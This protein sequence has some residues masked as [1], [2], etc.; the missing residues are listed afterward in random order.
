MAIGNIGNIGNSLPVGSTTGLYGYQ[1]TS[2]PINGG[3]A[4]FYNITVQNNANIGNTLTVSNTI[5]TANLYTGNIYTDGYFYANGAQFIGGGSGG[6]SFGL[7]YVIPDG[8]IIPSLALAPDSSIKF[9]DT[10]F[11]VPNDGYY[12]LGINLITTTSA[13]V[14]ITAGLFADNV[15]VSNT[16]VNLGAAD[17]AAIGYGNL[18]SASGALVVLL[19]AGVTYTVGVWTNSFANVTVSSRQQDGYSSYSLGYLGADG[20]YSDL[21]VSRYLQGNIASNII[22][23]FNGEQILGNTARPWGTAFV[24]NV[25]IGQNSITSNGPN[26]QINE[27]TIVT[28]APNGDIFSTGNLF[29]VG[30]VTGTYLFGD[31]TFISNIGG[32]TNYGNANVAAFMITTTSNIG[33]VGFAPNAI[34]SNSYFYGNGEPF[35][36]GG[37]NGNAI[38]NGTSNVSILEPDGSIEFQVNGVDM[39]HIRSN[40]VAIGANAGLT[41]QL[42]DA[43]AIGNGAGLNTQGANTVAIGSG[44]GQSNQGDNAIAIGAFAGNTNQSANSIIINA[45]GLPLDTANTGFYVDPIRNDDLN[46]ANTVF[47]NQTTK[48]LTF[49]PASAASYGNANVELLLASGNID[50]NI[51]LSANGFFVGDGR[52]L[53]NIDA[54]NLIG[55]YGNANVAGFLPIYTGEM[56]SLEGD[57][58]TQANIVGNNIRTLGNI[59]TDNISGANNVIAYNFIGNTVRITGDADVGGNLNVIGNVNYSNI[60]E[61]VVGDSLVQIAAN[62]TTNLLDIGFFGQYN[63]GANIYTGFVRDYTDGN[64]KLFDNL[65]TQP[66]ANDKVDFANSVSGNLNIGILTATGNLTTTGNVVATGNV[67]GNYILGDGSQLINLPDSSIPADGETI[68]IGMGFAEPPQ[69][70]VFLGTNYAATDL[71]T[72]LSALSL[73]QDGDIITVTGTITITATLAINKR[74]FI[75][76][77]GTITTAGTSADP[78]TMLNITANNVV[79]GDNLTITHAKTTNTSVET[80]ITVNALNFVSGAE[81]NFVEFGY[82][83]R[84]SFNISGVVSQYVGGLANNHRHFTIFRVSAPSQISDIIYDF[85]TET[86]PRSSFIYVSTGGAGD[87]FT[88]SLVVKNT[89]QVDPLKIQRQ[90]YLQDT[91][92]NVNSSGIAFYNNQFNDLNGGIGFISASQAPL[93]AFAK[94]GILENTQGAAGAGIF[95]G[96]CYFD[97]SNGPGRNLGNTQ[98][99]AYNNVTAGGALRTDYTG[100]YETNIVAARN[101]I[102]NT[103]QQLVSIDDGYNDA[104]QQ[105]YDIRYSNANVANYLGSNANVSITTT[106]NVRVGNIFTDGYYYANGLP[107]AGGGNGG[108]NSISFGNTSVVIPSTGGNI[109]FT[110]A[111]VPY[112]NLTST[113]LALGNNAGQGAN[114]GNFTVALGHTAGFEFQAAYSVAVGALAGYSTQQSFSVAVGDSAGQDRQGVAAVAIGSRAGRILQ[115]DDATAVGHQAAQQRQGDSAVAIGSRAGQAN[116]GANSIAI[117]SLAGAGSL[118]ANTSG[119]GN[120][121][122]II[123]ATGSSLNQPLANTFTVAPI[124][125]N[126]ANITNGLYYNSITGEITVGQIGLV[127][128]GTTSIVIPTPNAQI[129]FNVS[130]VSNALSLSVNTTSNLATAQLTGSYISRSNVSTATSEYV[131]QSDGGSFI[132]LG[133]AGSAYNNV[134][135][136]A[137]SLGTS[138]SPLD[139]YLFTQGGNLVIGTNAAN[140]T[141]K[142]IAG[143][144]NIN[145]Q[146]GHLGNGVVS[147]GFANS[148]P[149]NTVV[150]NA[151]GN[152]LNVSANSTYI[153][154]VRPQG[155]NVA[156]GNAVYYNSTTREITTA[157]IPRFSATAS[158]TTVITTQYIPATVIYNT[159]QFDAEAWYDRNTGRYQPQRAGYYQINASARLFV[160]GTT[161]TFERYIIL[162][163]NGAQIN[164]AGGFGP[165]SQSISQVVFLNGTTD[166]VDVAVISQSTGNIGQ[167]AN[168]AVFSG[169]WISP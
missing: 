30:N 155:A 144:G 9:D 102:Y 19:A 54:G 151:S 48:E 1:G 89:R 122:I 65:A 35:I 136:P 21:D 109:Q 22:P 20:S 137:N 82:I 7:Q 32:A 112:G 75:T 31:G 116:Q 124:R 97:G 29:A 36:G 169:S 28:A 57:V 42:D 93:S 95:K 2:T 125:A 77:T 146:V 108:G 130:N 98:L 64:W 46:T 149:A 96:L 23:F 11:T 147:L 81:V 25:T 141:I 43:I 58:I 114:R 71:T 119:I 167:L 61:L 165:T 139:G 15:I 100:I 69:A 38:V 53:T 115:S 52:Y 13:G 157:V 40:S 49:G 14:A 138:L 87:S 152:T 127:S 126:V 26:V 111:N 41:F 24:N 101:T 117:G 83:L 72:L 50:S 45:T 106:G 84:G 162:R 5:S 161:Q 118:L 158:T 56:I 163:K 131:A 129:N 8:F 148:Y 68:L 34:F 145:N 132:D 99:Y 39:G 66:E 103:T 70:G 160:P 27:A 6:E 44:A 154:S 88:G 86:T 150:L 104:I 92:N 17:G 67:T 110:V 135:P 51:V 133:V 73:S 90:F 168:G 37:G 80:A 47:Y 78:V 85:P 140:R 16:S 159:V 3:N 134:S 120:N 121:S 63:N 4:K 94:F 59:F 55:G 76:G 143:G 74:L 166:Y 123:N 142:F 113:S 18:R 91:F 164:Q 128:S 62:N 156:I 60:S 79:L 153:S 105:L 33:T 107:F 10:G 12:V